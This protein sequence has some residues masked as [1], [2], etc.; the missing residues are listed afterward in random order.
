MLETKNQAG[1]LITAAIRI[2][3]LTCSSGAA[4]ALYLALQRF[5]ALQASNVESR[6]HTERA[7]TFPLALTER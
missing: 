1:D 2:L 5:Q 7:K 3:I 4:V 6:Q